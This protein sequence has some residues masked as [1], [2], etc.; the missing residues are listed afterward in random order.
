MANTIKLRRGTAAQWTSANSVLAAGEPG[1]ETDTNKFKIG[2]G[3]ASWNNLPY[4]AVDPSVASATYAT[5]ASPSF[6]GTP[7]APTAASGTNT[8]Q[9]ATT[10]FVR[11]EISNLVNSAPSA[12]DTLNELA[13]ALGNDANFST[14]VTNSIATKLDTA[15]ASTLY[16][17]ISA[18]SNFVQKS[19]LTTTSTS[20]IYRLTLLDSGRLIEMNSS[21]PNVFVIPINASVAFPV[22]T[23]I[24]IVQVGTGR[25]TASA[26]AGVILNSESNKRNIN[27]QWS[28]ATLIKRDTDTWML[29]GALSI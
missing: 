3:T 29:L 22:G 12:L 4:S 15:T 24:D 17:P 6:T 18:S 14:T 13:T 10:Q 5:I 7:L 20:A 21:A 23:Q 11:S 28:S 26:D 25:T 27:A 8:T 19:I 9:I 16:L 1:F 2:T